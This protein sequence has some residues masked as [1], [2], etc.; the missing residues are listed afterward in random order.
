MSKECVFENMGSEFYS[1]EIL[2][3]QNLLIF[4]KIT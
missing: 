1:Q 4:V 3:S 2:L